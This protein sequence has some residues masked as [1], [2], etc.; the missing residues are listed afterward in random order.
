MNGHQAAEGVSRENAIA[1]GAVALLDLRD[2]FGLDKV[3]EAVAAATSGISES[4]IRRL[5]V[6]VAGGEVASAV[7]VGDAHNDERRHAVVLYQKVDGAAD[8]VDMRGAVHEVEHRIGTRGLIGAGCPDP[9]RPVLIEH[10][11]V[12]RES[13][14]YGGRNILGGGQRQQKEAGGKQHQ[15]SPKPEAEV[16]DNLRVVAQNMRGDKPCQGGEAHTRRW[17][18]LT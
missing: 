4:A 17:D 3:E 9:D 18:T 13:L 16:H 11:G 1:R 12:Q 2:Q 8:L 14:R 6:R 7:G 15:A 5:L 10:R